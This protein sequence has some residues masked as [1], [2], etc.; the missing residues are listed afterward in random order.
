MHFVEDHDADAEQDNHEREGIAQHP[1]FVAAYT[2]HAVLEELDDTREGIQLHDEHQ[3]R[4][5]D[6]RER[7]D[8]WRSVHPEADEEREQ[9]LQVAVLGGHTGEED[10]EAEC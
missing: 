1:P 6:G 5:G 2:E 10:T 7:V 9:E 3:F 4:I 8:N